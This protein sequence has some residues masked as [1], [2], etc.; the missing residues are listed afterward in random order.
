MTSNGSYPSG[1]V[2]LLVGT[3]RGLF[4]LSSENRRDW[5]IK[6]HTLPG[7]VVYN[8][9]LDQ[10]GGSPRMFATDNNVFF[11]CKLMYSDDL[12]KTWQEPSKNIE[13]PEESGLK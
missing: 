6:E 9:T 10:R 2:L 8:A 1:S 11:G 3:K 4:V 13:F 5:A 12:G 7:V